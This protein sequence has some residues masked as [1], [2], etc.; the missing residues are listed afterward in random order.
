[1]RLAAAMDLKRIS[2]HGLAEGCSV[3]HCMAGWIGLS[4]VPASNAS[5]LRFVVDY[6][7]THAVL[8]MVVLRQFMHWAPGDK[9][10]NAASAVLLVKQQSTRT[11]A[12]FLQLFFGCSRAS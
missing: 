12:V 3:G 10:V 2:T 4:R 7:T 9:K 11:D 5:T 1:M 6:G 8:L